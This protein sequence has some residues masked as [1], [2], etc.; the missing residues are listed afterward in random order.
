MENEL[1]MECWTLLPFPNDWSFV[2][3]TTKIGQ[4]TIIKCFSLILY[5][6]RSQF[7]IAPAMKPHMYAYVSRSIKFSYWLIL[8]IQLHPNCWVDRA[9]AYDRLR[10]CLPLGVHVY[11]I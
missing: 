7:Q 11:K 6:V 4:M 9:F 1:F 10:Y 8:P 3:Q 5:H 2:K